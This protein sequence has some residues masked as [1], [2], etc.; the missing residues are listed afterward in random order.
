VVGSQRRV[1]STGW[2]VNIYLFRYVRLDCSGWF[3]HF[4]CLSKLITKK[5]GW[6]L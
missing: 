4:S 5:F 2:S 1:A 3:G 6:L